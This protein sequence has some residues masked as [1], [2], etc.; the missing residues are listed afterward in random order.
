M[1]MEHSSLCAYSY[2]ATFK[3]NPFNHFNPLG[4]LVTVPRIKDIFSLFKNYVNSEKMLLAPK[5]E[6]KTTTLK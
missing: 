4:I 6:M 1:E 2:V 5:Y 3:N